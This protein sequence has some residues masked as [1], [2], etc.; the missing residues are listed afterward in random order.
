MCICFWNQTC[1]NRKGNYLLNCKS[2]FMTW[3]KIK[4]FITEILFLK[5]LMK[6]H[7]DSSSWVSGS[8]RDYCFGSWVSHFTRVSGPTFTVPCIIRFL[9]LFLIEIHSIHRWTATT[10]WVTR[11]RTTKRLKHTGNL[12]RKNLQLKGVCK[13]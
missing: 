6:I 5:L 2:G 8:T 11:K 4:K 10:R 12:F 13:F 7:L 3:L 9:S 1:C